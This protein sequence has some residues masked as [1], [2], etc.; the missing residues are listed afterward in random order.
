M[1]GLISRIR[2]VPGRR[3]DLLALLLGGTGAMAGC[4]SYVV[5]RDRDDADGLWVTEVWTDKAAHRASLRQ[6]EVAAAIEAARPLIAGFDQR[7]LTEP[8]GGVGL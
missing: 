8:V 2:A 6:P 7:F 4:L 5:A 1:Y 3:D